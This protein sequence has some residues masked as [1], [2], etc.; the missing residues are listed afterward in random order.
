MRRLGGGAFHGAACPVVEG[1]R[2]GPFAQLA[3]FF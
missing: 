1:A 2:C 3:V